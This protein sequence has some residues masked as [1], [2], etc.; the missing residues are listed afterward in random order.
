MSELTRLIPP[1]AR[2]RQLAEAYMDAVQDFW[3]TDEDTVERYRAYCGGYLTGAATREYRALMDTHPYYDQP[4]ELIA[5][6][7]FW[8]GVHT[9]LSTVARYAIADKV[10]FAP[11]RMVH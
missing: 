7:A 9:F 11:P 8:R 1:H 6:I 5:E 4:P 3:T 10:R 2:L